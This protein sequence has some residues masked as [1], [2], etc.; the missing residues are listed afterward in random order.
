MYLNIIFF[1]LLASLQANNRYCGS[2][3]G[4]IQSVLC[5]KK[6]AICCVTIFY[7]VGLS[8]SPVSIEL[9]NW[10]DYGNILIEWNLYFDSLT[11]TMYQPIVLISFLIQKYSLEYLHNDPHISRFFSLLSLFAV[12]MLILVTG[13]NLLII[14][15]GWEGDCLKSF[16]EL[17]KPGRTKNKARACAPPI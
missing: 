16:L 1:P 8:G 15:L 11:V 4:P 5:K 7:E 3:G 12:T 9:G 13:E 2:K 10:I 6:A 14:Q 17:R